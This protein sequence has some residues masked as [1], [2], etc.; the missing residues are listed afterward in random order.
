[1]IW[2]EKKEHTKL[3]YRKVG[4]QMDCGNGEVKLGSFTGLL[5]VSSHKLNVRP[6][7]VVV[8][9]SPHSAA[10]IQARTRWRSEFNKCRHLVK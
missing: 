7:R 8:F 6:V 5:K 10:Q 2:R 1:M 9:F 4:G 3:S